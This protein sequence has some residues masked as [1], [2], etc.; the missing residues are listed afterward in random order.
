MADLLREYVQDLAAEVELA[1][2]EHVAGSY[3]S[4]DWRDRESDL[5]WRVRSQ[6]NVLCARATTF[7]ASA[8]GLSP[9]TGRS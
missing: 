9:A 4:E 6:I 2:L 5:V 1:T 8:L 7:T 3:V